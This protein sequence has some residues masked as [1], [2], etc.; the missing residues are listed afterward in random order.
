MAIGCPRIVYIMTPFAIWDRAGRTRQSVSLDRSP[1]LFNWRIF[2]DPTMGRSAPFGCL[3]QNDLF[4]IE[5][6]HDLA[7]RSCTSEKAL[8]YNMS[9]LPL[10]GVPHRARSE[11]RMEPFA[12]EKR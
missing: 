4:L 8:A 9:D 10:D 7:I 3:P 11:F 12:H 1:V 2:S 6:D 5:G